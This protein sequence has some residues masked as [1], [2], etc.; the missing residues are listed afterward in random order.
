M[1]YLIIPPTSSNST[2]APG[3]YDEAVNRGLITQPQPRTTYDDI[4]AQR[5][6]PIIQAQ[7]VEEARKKACGERI[8]GGI[9]KVLLGTVEAFHGGVTFA[10]GTATTATV[11]GAPVGVFMMVGGGAET[12]D[13]V[14]RFIEGIQDIYHGIRGDT[15]TKSVNLIKDTFFKGKEDW[16]NLLPMLLGQTNQEMSNTASIIDSMGLNKSP[17]S[18]N[19]ED[20]LKS[21]DPYDILKQKG[22]PQTLTDDEIQFLN[23]YNV[24]MR[25]QNSDNI[26]RDSY[27]N[28]LALPSPNNIARDSYG[29]QLALPSRHIPG[30]P[31][32]VT[33]GNSTTL[34][35]NIL[36][37]MG[38]PKS[39]KWSGY[40]AQ[41]IIPA[42]LK[43]NQ[44]LQKIGMDLDD[45]SNGIFL[46]TSNQETSTMARHTGYHSVYNNVVESQLNSLNI[47]QS[48]NVLDN[49]VFTL[50]N[51]L[52]SL[53]EQGLP[54]YPSQ[55]ATVDLWNR[56]LNK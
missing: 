27:G 24:R 23:E 35:K 11:F 33:G 28:Q 1:S 14:S 44:V 54:L 51:K 46:R 9:D 30:T 49:Q 53:Q 29:N 56:Y 2:Y 25:M 20:N 7:E 38:V 10:A 48:I 15:Q 43:S 6:S 19:N 37:S 21:T 45:A 26:A 17:I 3:S 55:G 4:E 31:G 13:G 32:L 34:G 39:Q 42:Q 18:T 8:V 50:Q 41:H 40:Q 36:E 22:I 16:Y 47:N 52:R 12:A 5:L